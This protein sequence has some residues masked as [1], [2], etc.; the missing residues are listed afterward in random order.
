[1]CDCGEDTCVCLYPNEDEG[2]ENYCGI[3]GDHDCMGGL[4]CDTGD[5]V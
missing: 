3:C 5:G 4:P 1:M 2:E